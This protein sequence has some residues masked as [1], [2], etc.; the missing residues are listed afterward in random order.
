L[1]AKRRGCSRVKS[2]IVER[3][4]D[5]GSSRGFRG[6]LLQAGWLAGIPFRPTQKVVTPPRDLSQECVSW[7]PPTRAGW[8]TSKDSD[9][10]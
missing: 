3:E 7:Q 2:V 6:D 4:H 5:S 9:L 8:T 1:L 10:G